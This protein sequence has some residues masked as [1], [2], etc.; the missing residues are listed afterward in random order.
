MQSNAW[1]MSPSLGVEW[2][3]P[4]PASQDGIVTTPYN[5]M[6]AQASISLVK[7]ML[8]GLSHYAGGGVEAMNLARYWHPKMSWY[9]PAGIGSNRRISGFRSWHQR[10]FLNAMPDREMTGETC[11]FIGDGN[12]VGFTAWPGMRA[13]ISGN[14]WMGIAPSNKEELPLHPNGMRFEALDDNRQTTNSWDV[15]SIGGGALLEKTECSNSR[16]F[17]P[18]TTM[19]AVLNDC[20]ISGRTFWQYVEKCEGSE[21]WDFLA[22]VWKTM[23]NS[24]ERG[25]AT[26]GM[27]PGHLKISRKAKSLYAKAKKQSAG[28]TLRV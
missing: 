22:S 11:T 20:R 21:I 12:Y 15:Y 27:L 28:A 2:L 16:S 17:Y 14:G 8:T 9:G 1:P 5:E 4:G 10:S 13:N 23:K 7:D 25:L 18:L 26:E 3:V 6:K 24:L 19:N